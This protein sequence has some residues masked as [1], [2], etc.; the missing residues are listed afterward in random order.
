MIN[1]DLMNS[2]LMNSD[3]INKQ[4]FMTSIHA[5]TKN[6]SDKNMVYGIERILRSTSTRESIT[7]N[8]VI[9]DC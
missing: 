3:M 1:S 5:I 2:D 9:I 7:R 8:Y 6:D 4:L